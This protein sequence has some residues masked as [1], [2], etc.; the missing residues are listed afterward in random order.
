MN[1][2]I[3]VMKLQADNFEMSNDYKGID[4]TLDRYD[5]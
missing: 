3:P 5:N 4:K 2:L 1:Q